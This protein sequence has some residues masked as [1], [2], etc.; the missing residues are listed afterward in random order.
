[1]DFMVG[2]QNLSPMTSS[3]S[4]LT[5]ESSALAK[6]DLHPGIRRH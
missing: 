1:M 5:Q 2:R 6:L 4:T 3:G